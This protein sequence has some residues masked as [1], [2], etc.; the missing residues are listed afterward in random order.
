MHIFPPRSPVHACLA[1]ML[2]NSPSTPFPYSPSLLL[3]SLVGLPDKHSFTYFLFVPLHFPASPICLLTLLAIPF[4]VSLRYSTHVL[5]CLV[6]LPT[7]SPSSPLSLLFVE[8]SILSP[9]SSPFPCSTQLHPSLPSDSTAPLPCP[10]S[11]FLHLASRHI[12]LLQIPFPVPLSYR[13]CP[14][15]SLLSLLAP[16]SWYCPSRRDYVNKPGPSPQLR[17]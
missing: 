6:H 5:P 11:P 2:T 10:P 1:H 16:P 3:S 9:L 7:H 8:Y 15:A 17:T 12:A 4:P 13:T 14:L